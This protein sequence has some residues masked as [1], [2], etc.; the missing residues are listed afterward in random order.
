[1]G[2]SGVLLD[3]DGTIIVDSGYVGSVDRVEFINGSIDAIA[4]LNAAGIPVAVVTN[5]AGVARGYYGIED[6]D[7]V[8]AHIVRELSRRGAH[9]DMWLSCPY[10]P[11]GVVDAFAR[12]SSDRKPSPGMALAAARALDLD[13]STSWVV[14]DSDVDVDLARAVG[15]RALLVNGT[16]DDPE[17]EA[18][19]DLAAAVRVILRD[20]RRGTSRARA[21]QP[22]AHFPLQRYDS[23]EV[24]ARHYADEISRALATVDF[25]EIDRAAKVLNSAYDRDAAVFACGNGGSASIA[26]HLQC[27][28]VKGVRTG[29]DLHTRVVSLSA[30]VELLSA[31]ANDVG[32]DSVFEFQLE[33]QARS[34]DVLIVISSS[35]RSPNIVRALEWAAA[36]DLQTIALTGFEGS[37][38]RELAG[39]SIHVRSCNYGVVED[40][41]QACMHLLAQFVRQSRMTADAVAAQ[42]F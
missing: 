13:L 42:V 36:H 4:A 9:V 23:A 22:T 21:V 5:Q 26:N 2:R 33:S 10:H 20:H 12:A 3:R 17:V 15:A 41:H 29:T 38:A 7:A 34:G 40:A 31:V 6:V 35:G 1:M 16:S 27:D 39:V 25:G 32:Y 37:P 24:F 11:D 8:H 19:L 30:N 28:H 14:G 18:V